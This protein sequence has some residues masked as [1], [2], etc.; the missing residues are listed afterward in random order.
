MDVQSEAQRAPRRPK[1]SLPEGTK[2]VANGP[3]N[4]LPAPLTCGW[5]THSVADERTLRIHKRFCTEKPTLPVFHCICCNLKTFPSL[6]QLSAHQRTCISNPTR[7]AIPPDS[8]NS[9][10]C[11]NLVVNSPIQPHSARDEAS[12]SPLPSPAP[13]PPPPSQPKVHTT[14]P[15]ECPPIPLLHQ[16]PKLLLPRGNEAKV[17]RDIEADLEAAIIARFPPEW[18][19]VA[20]LDEVALDFLLFLYNWLSKRCGTAAPPQPRLPRSTAP[21]RKP[22]R[23]KK[24]RQRSN[25]LKKLMA[26]Y[27][28]HN[29]QTDYAQARSELSR[30]HRQLSRLSKMFRL[31]QLRE[32]TVRTQLAFNRDHW[33]FAKRTFE[34]ASS[35]FSID[36]EETEAYFKEAYTDPSR[37]SPFSPLPGLPRPP[38]P[39]VP[40]G[41]AYP[42]F[43]HFKRL[44]Q[45]KS[46]GSA[47]GPYGVPYKVYKRFRCAAAKL[48]LI[49]RRVVAERRTPACWGH[50]Y[51]ILLTKK[52]RP[53]THAKHLRNIACSST[54]GK[55]FWTGMLGMLDPFLTKNRY[56][57][58]AV[59]KGARPGVPGC[60]EHT[61]SAFEALKNAKKHKR[62][63]SI[64]FT[65]L[66]N[67]YGSLKH[68]LIQFALWWYHVPDWFAE[69]AFHYYES[70]IV[71][72]VT[73]DWSTCPFKYGT[74]VY[75]GCVV[76]CTFFILA[77]QIMIDYVDTHGVLPFTFKTQ[78]RASPSILQQA[79]VD[80]HTLFNCAPE[81]SQYNFELLLVALKWTRC[82]VL[83]LTVG[84]CSSFALGDLRSKGGKSFGPFDPNIRNG[85]VP[86]MFLDDAPHKYLGRA[87]IT[88]APSTDTFSLVC[89]A[90]IQ[91]L[92]TIDKLPLSGLSKVWFYQY[93]VIQRFL[94]WPFITSCF[95]VSRIQR[96]FEAP[97]VRYLKKWLNMN[98]PANPAILFLPK[99]HHGR[100][101]TSPVDLY[102]SLQVS[103]LHQLSN[104]SDPLITSLIANAATEVSQSQANSWKASSALSTAE[105]TLDFNHAFGGQ[106]G[107]T[108][109]GYQ[110][111]L[112]QKSMQRQKRRRSEIVSLVRNEETNA[113][114]AQLRDLPLSGNFLRWEGL[115]SASPNLSHQIL[116]MSEAE[117]KF[118]LNAQAQSLPSPGNLRRWGCNFNARCLLCSKPAAT[119]KHT[120]SSCSTALRQGR[121]LWRH[122]NVLRAVKTDL[123]G[124]IARANRTPPAFFPNPHL[125]SFIPAGTKPPQTRARTARPCLL[126]CACDWKVKIDLHD[127]LLFPPETGVSTGLR[128]DVVIWSKASKTVIWGELTCP[129]EEN[130]PEAHVRKKRRYLQL[131]VDCRVK[132]W[133]VHAFQFEVGAIGFVANSAR[134]FFSSLGC[135]NPQFKHVSERMSS[136]SRRSSFHIWNCRRSS[137]WIGPPLGPRATASPPPPSPRVPFVLL[138]APLQDRANA[139]KVAARL[140]L[141]NRNNTT[142]A[143]VPSSPLLP[144]PLPSPPHANKVVTTPA[145]VP[146]PPLLPSLLPFPPPAD[147]V[148]SSPLLLS[149]SPPLLPS[150]T[151]LRRRRPLT[152]LELERRFANLSPDPPASAPRV[153]KIQTVRL[154]EFGLPADDFVLNVTAPAHPP[155]ESDTLMLLELEAMMQL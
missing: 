75:Q 88:G 138:P 126:S 145:R 38:P 131:E 112:R 136:S 113:R 28:K 78:D 37:A 79:F 57:N 147:Q 110:Q 83:S 143:R 15:A 86:V 3:Q 144:S 68:N 62:L 100:G 120:L 49:C 53:K 141:H 121:Y 109:L 11:A 24:L 116:F 9:A 130:I 107:K 108:G 81:G 42:D 76:A 66:A 153:S 119:A 95:S 82:L 8:I 55:L 102:K 2:C 22:H 117:L 99:E 155:S 91:A 96:K 35:T 111:I 47:P 16:R 134:K 148:P 32:E 97:L 123:E 46:A 17:C 31:D 122:N 133:T 128:P 61:W 89:E 129:L 12:S 10:N 30:V 132:G 84:K 135:P 54:A 139:N 80:D 150:P 105:S 58:P 44:I 127:N 90:F 18:W 72:V 149:F 65:D 85:D 124:L 146:S 104:S 137:N 140:R 50:A 114:I 59:N 7:P 151:G 36:K 4:D 152:D 92:E 34:P 74:G 25:R 43:S 94:N 13:S 39:S 67:A 154:D 87:N 23:H 142:P 60:L 125:I 103:S 1:H 106:T 52:N 14:L 56:L 71:Y 115:S 26:K 51:M 6:K 20:P 5:C 29:Q 118:L 64:L 33:K 27:R 93:P 98:K 73:S 41:T 40:F 19:N 48:H 45:K 69:T 101:L 70:L 63:I 21:K 77:Y